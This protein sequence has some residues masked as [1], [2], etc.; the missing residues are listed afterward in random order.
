ML[1]REE[2]RER[3]LEFIDLDALANLQMRVEKLP[4]KLKILAE[5]FIQYLSQSEEKHG[6][7]SDQTYGYRAKVKFEVDHWRTVGVGLEQLNSKEK[8]N[9]FEAL[10]PKFPEAALG[11][12]ELKKTLPYQQGYSRR[13]FRFEASHPIQLEAA[14]KYIRTLLIDTLAASED[15][16]WFATWAAYIHKPM[17]VAPLLAAGI[18]MGESQVYDILYASLVGEHE[19]AAMGR[20]VLS[21]FMMCDKEEAWIAVEKTLLAAQR[22]EG[23]RQSILTYVDES[24]PEAYKRMLRLIAEHNLSRFSASVS[25]VN[26][27][28]GFQFE[29]GQSK[30]L[31]ALLVEVADY[32]D[33]EAKRQEALNNGS[34]QELFLALW[35]IAFQDVEAALE[36]AQN[37]FDDA[38]EE[39]RF[40][41][42]H[43]VKMLGTKNGQTALQPLLHDTSLQIAMTAL[44][45]FSMVEGSY[46]HL[47]NYFE[48]VETFFGNLPSSKT[49][50]LKPIIWPWN[51]RVLERSRIVNELFTAL[52]DRPI[53]CLMPYLGDMD[54]YG[55]G[56][57]IRMLSTQ[58]KET[59]Y[60]DTSHRDALLEFVTDRNSSVSET[61]IREVAKFGLRSDDVLLMEGLLT[62]KTASLRRSILTLLLTQE[63][64]AVFESVDRLIVSKKSP[65][66]FAGLELLNELKKAEREVGKTQ[67]LT[68][69]FQEARGDSL[70]A[71]E[72]TIVIGILENNLEEPSREDGFGL[73]DPNNMGEVRVPVSY[74]ALAEQRPKSGVGKLIANLVKT[75]NPAKASTISSKE[76][77]GKRVFTSEHSASIVEALDA[78]IHSYRETP[79]K[80]RYSEEEVLLGNVGYLQRP[81]PKPKVAGRLRLYDDSGFESLEAAWQEIVLSETWQSWWD[82]KQLT[83][84]DSDGFEALRALTSVEFSKWRNYHS[85]TS[86]YYQNLDAAWPV[87]V[88]LYGDNHYQLNYPNIVSCLLNWLFLFEASRRLEPTVDFLLDAV[89]TSLAAAQKEYAGWLKKETKRIA[90]EKVKL[91][92]PDA[93]VRLRTFDFNLDYATH[94]QTLRQYS[95]SLWTEAQQ[96]RFIDILRVRTA[97]HSETTKRPLGQEVFQDVMF[98]WQ[99]DWLSDDFIYACFVGPRAAKGP[100]SIH[101]LLTD[102]TGLT[103][104]KVIEYYPKL[105]EIVDKCR[106]R[107][108]EVELARADLPT[109]ASDLA[110]NIR[111]IYGADKALFILKSLDRNG[112]VR[113]YTWGGG[114]NKGDVF[115]RLLRGS[116]PNKVDTA[117]S[118]AKHAKA[119][120]LKE[121]RLVDLAIYAPQWANFVEQ[122]LGWKGFVEA[123]YWLHAHTKDT[124][125]SVDKAIRDGWTAEVSERTPLS[126]KELLDGA[127][128]V[129]WFKRVYKTLGEE[130]WKSID[131]AAKYGSSSGGH[132]RAQ[133]FADALLGELDAEA[134]TERLEAKRHQDSVRALGL[135]PLPKAKKAAKAEVLSR[136]EVIQTFIH[137]SRKFGSQRKASERLCADIGLANLARTAGYQ[138]PQRLMWAME[139]EACADLAKGPISVTEGETTVSLYI[140]DDAKVQ[141][142]VVKVV[143]GKEKKL[144]AIPAKLKKHPEISILRDR[145]TE[146][147]K[148]TSRMRL[149]LEESMIRGDLFSS[150][151]FIELCAHPLLRAMLTDLLFIT[152]DS[153]L[154]FPIK[155]GKSLES[156][157]KSEVQLGKT[158]LRIAHPYDLLQSD[159]WSEW[160]KNCFDVERKQS[161]KQIFRELYICSEAEQKTPLYSKRYEGHQVESR[162]A[163]GILG[164][165]NWIPV[166]EEGLRKSFH[167]EG[168]SAWIYFDHFYY[169]AGDS[170]GLTTDT[171][172]FTHRDKPG[173][174]PLNEVPPRLFS[175]VMRDLDLMVSVAHRGGVD[176][177]ASAS[178]VEM[179]ANLL[180]ETLQLLK[181]NNVRLENTHALIKGDLGSYSVHMGSANVHRQPG[182]SVCIIPVHSQ[183]RGR[184]FLPFAD[185]DPKT[186]EVI[187]KVIML[188][189]D[190]QI[191]DPTILE[192]IL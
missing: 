80:R 97:Y 105:Q 2:S 21:A 119:L 157:D 17:T 28:F 91:S 185:D 134:C 4:K 5:G 176:P 61:A 153:A 81:F 88:D 145:K 109:E 76:E 46:N 8:L 34:G 136:Y 44:D 7:I 15:L 182:G 146:L 104:N 162:Q 150:I 24:H 137:G 37:T 31:D 33:D 179:R 172:A 177:E 189:K 71:E 180:R 29:T 72:K 166:H 41:A 125:W 62:R 118:F 45:S 98:A 187:S 36:A 99:K 65:L 30:K 3:L 130:R 86:Y 69:A 149:S 131:A 154:G 127:V 56:R 27:W 171:V 100:T 93:H 92:D 129:S 106:D 64:D 6:F 78:F 160:Q 113:G 175:E 163:I 66:R 132:K 159:K 57:V 141:L 58:A 110:V 151:E 158:M 9:L 70:T 143:K 54:S 121:Q 178:T 107:V 101:F 102:F 51:E 116:Y 120:K 174:L 87:Q 1:P 167:A 40:A 186:A 25:S 20:H 122:T 138:D 140:D 83:L 77:T 14:S 18:N 68:K 108:V 55:R 48:E 191:K 42:A 144:K 26:V 59:N 165:R 152:E 95:F 183:H 89:E 111:T 142:D 90:D 117:E 190:K 181:I 161:F 43:L 73:F 173:L 188:A 184:I 103:P 49:K 147:T 47:P 22:Q 192:Q 63:D 12:W 50:T 133:L 60:S 112:L 67:D 96:K 82:E 114:K 169:S 39:R 53:T 164:K 75:V 79:V 148:Q 35:T 115:S 85:P 155:D 94:L 23:L 170:D 135:I 19:I 38:D 16:N 32:F 52:E 168:L 128:D 10:F 13:S 126:A 156:Y 139:A 74:L 124:S 11:A 123:V 84:K